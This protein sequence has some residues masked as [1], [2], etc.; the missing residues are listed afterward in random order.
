LERLAK[1]C[2]VYSH[3]SLSPMLTEVPAAASS[4]SEMQAT[5]QK[6]FCFCLPA[7]A[8]DFFQKIY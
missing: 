2:G 4:F 1:K 5:A 7:A 3:R 6:H 8:F